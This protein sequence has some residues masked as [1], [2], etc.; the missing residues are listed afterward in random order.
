V[1]TSF[2]FRRSILLVTILCFVILIPMT[3][4]AGISVSG[5][6]LRANISPGA[7]LTHVM[8]VTSGANDASQNFTAEVM[9]FANAQDGGYFQLDRSIDVS[10]YTAR[11]FITLN[12]TSFPLNPGETKTIL[13]T[14]KIPSNVGDGGRYAIINIRGSAAKTGQVAVTTAINVPIILT[15][16]GS[17]LIEAG[18]IES[19]EYQKP[20]FTGDPAKIVTSFKNT[21]NIHIYH[22]INEVEIKDSAGTIVFSKI[23][24]PFNFA[25]LPP[26]T[27][28][29]TV[30]VESALS[31]GS[32]TVI[33]TTK[34]ENGTVFSESS[35]SFTIEKQY[36]PPFVETSVTLDPT[37]SGVLVTS[38]GRV[39]IDFPQGAVLDTISVT[40]KAVLPT[41]LPSPGSEAKVGSIFF[42]VEGITGLLSKDA[43]LS[44]KYS[45]DDLALAG[46]NPSK[47]VLARW[48]KVNSKWTYVSTAVDPTVGTLKAT[49]NRLSIWAIMVTEGAVPI[50]TDAQVAT[51]KTP[52][53][54]V[55]IS[56]AALSFLLFRWRSKR[57]E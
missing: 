42:S 52:G 47:L 10:K 12:R 17:K 29:I 46:G 56:I 54:E 14:I 51:T 32:Y 3:V 44:V 1:H 34:S 6:I 21:G 7:T 9:G 41:N 43:T 18:K 50:E 8:T 4:S 38:D 31:P 40:L 30:F 36:V 48:D 53:F 22:L 57:G 28:Q 24:E 45:L 15:I 23:R 11:P 37:K 55:L 5:G 33:S 2:K 39:S 20:L 13:A 25:I 26:F 16:D 27:V 19:V 49:T 35:A